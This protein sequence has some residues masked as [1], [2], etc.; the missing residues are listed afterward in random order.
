MRLLEFKKT[1][2]SEARLQ[3]CDEVC[4]LAARDALHAKNFDLLP[5]V[6]E[7][8]GLE[9]FLS[10]AGLLLHRILREV[11]LRVQGR[12]G[13]G[14]R[15]GDGLPVDV[16]C[17]VASSKESWNRCLRVADMDVAGLIHLHLALEEAS[18]RVVANRDERG[19]DWQLLGLLGAVLCIHE[20][21]VRELL[22]LVAFPIAG[23]PSDEALDCRVP[24]DRDVGVANH[25]LLQDQAST[26]GVSP[27]DQG[28][29]AADAR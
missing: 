20:L 23:C 17:H 21:Q 8:P 7:G 1:S 6:F 3:R 22:P 29:C 12:H 10:H 14:S 11:S 27:M 13:P 19:I 16:I 18:V 15:R 4:L 25:P 24:S 28:H 2:H 5:Q 26:E 9:V